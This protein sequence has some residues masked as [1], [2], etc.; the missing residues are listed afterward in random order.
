MLLAPMIGIID[1]CILF[2]DE[3]KDKDKDIDA[4][5]FSA[6]TGMNGSAAA[7]VESTLS[8]IDSIECTNKTDYEL[9]YTLHIP[10]LQLFHCINGQWEIN[11]IIVSKV[12]RTIC[13]TS[14]PV[15]LYLFSTHFATHAPI[16]EYLA[17]NHRNLLIAQDGPLE[18]SIYFGSKIYNWTFTTTNNEIT[19]RRV[20][21]IQAIINELKNISATNL[22]KIRGITLLG[23][24]H[25]LFPDFESGMTFDALY[26]ITDYSQQSCIDFKKYLQGEFSKIENLNHFLQSNFL[27]FDEV[28][29]PSKNVRVDSS[30]KLVEH[31][32]SFAHGFLPVSGWVFLKNPEDYLLSWV[33][34]YCDGH[35]VGKVQVQHDRQD[36]LQAKPEFGHSQVGWRLDIDFRKLSAGRH[37]FHIYLEKGHH[38]FIYLGKRDIEIFQQNKK[39]NPLP[40]SPL[41]LPIAEKPSEDIQYYIDLPKNNST[42]FYN[43]L[44]PIWH[45]FRQLQV[46]RYLKFFDDLLESSHISNIPRYMHQILPFM[47]PGWDSNKFSVDKSLKGVGNLHL[48]VC[49]FGWPAHGN[50]FITYQKNVANKK[51]AVTEFHPMKKLNPKEMEDVLKMHKDNGADFLSFFIEPRWKDTLVKRKKYNVFSF[52]PLSNL[53]GSDVLYESM[54]KILNKTI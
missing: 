8:S 9:G 26:K 34:V 10:L 48:G 54:K 18:E 45:N 35:L 50:A 3:N 46:V 29:P 13:D 43:P 32:D 27:S 51:Y 28:N 19:F 15:I 52:D 11:N 53:H 41:L 2:K 39:M 17:K 49:L 21:A 38:N 33:C 5:L 24:V 30:A 1:T 25:H 14:R 22:K 31:I 16:E 7:L 44:V 12:I 20:Q 42:Y 47:N 37:I 36:V 6:C 40:F 23:E 4:D